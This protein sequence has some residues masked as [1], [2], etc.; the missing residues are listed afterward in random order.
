MS[1]VTDENHEHHQDSQCADPPTAGLQPQRYKNPL[2]FSMP[3]EFQKE[4][5]GRG[6]N[7]L[8]ILAI[9]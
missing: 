8:D 4:L 2:G 1:E 7:G 6:R 5:G 9:T 3:T